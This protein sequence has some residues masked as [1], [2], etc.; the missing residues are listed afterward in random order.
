MP[1]SLGM[2]SVLIKR[3]TSMRFNLK[4]F[5]PMLVCRSFTTFCKRTSQVC[6]TLVLMS[7]RSSSILKRLFHAKKYNTCKLFSELKC[8]SILWKTKR[9]IKLIKDKLTL[10]VILRWDHRLLF[11]NSVETHEAGLRSKLQRTI[12][13]NVP[14]FCYKD[15]FVAE[16]CKIWCSKAKRNV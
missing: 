9:M 10:W 8:S 11:T 16:P 5:L 6:S 1:L 14:S 7:T 15:W 2:D 12:N 13:A 4:H 3:Q